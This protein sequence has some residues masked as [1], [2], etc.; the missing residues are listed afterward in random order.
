MRN[1]ADISD[2]LL[3]EARI[4]VLPGSAFLAEGYLRISYAASMENIRE[5]MDRMEAALSKLK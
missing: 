5:G 2:Y 1:S 4:A 3:G